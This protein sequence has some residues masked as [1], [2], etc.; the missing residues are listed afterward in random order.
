MSASALD[1]R[2]LTLGDRCDRCG[3]QA[4]VQ[5]TMPSGLELQFC[6][7]HFTEHEPILGT[8]GAT[9][10]IDERHTLN[11]TPSVSANAA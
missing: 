10:T 3:A 11:T 5:A 1:T 7:H 8:Q 2:T 9:V 6:G 4:F